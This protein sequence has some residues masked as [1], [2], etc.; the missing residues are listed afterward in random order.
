MHQIKA[1]STRMTIAAMAVASVFSSTLL[2]A[3]EPV[4]T[5]EK[6]TKSETT[7][8]EKIM[9]TAQRRVENL[10][11]TPVAITAVSAETM[12]LARVDSISNISLLT[13]SIK[14]DVTNSAANS[15]N[16]IIRGIGTVGNSRAFEGAVGVFIDGVYRTRAGQAMQNWLDVDSLQILRGPQGTLFG[17]NTSAGAVLIESTK[18]QLNENSVNYEVSAGDYGYLMARAALNVETGDNTAIRIAGLTSKQDGFIENPNGGDYN[19]KSPTAVKFQIYSEP[20]DTFNWQFIAD[21]SKE[22]VNCCYGQVDDIDGPLQPLINSFILAR[23]LELPSSDFEDYQQ[24]LSNDTDQSVKDAGAVLKMNWDLGDNLSL[25]SVTGYRNWKISQ[26]NMDADF[27]GANILGITES[28]ETSLI[29]QEF[30]L[31]GEIATDSLHSANYIFGVYYADEEIDAHHEL[32]WGNQ[33]QAYFDIL[34]GL[35]PGTADATEGKWS[36]LDMPATSETK[37]VFTH[38]KL[39][40]TEKLG[41]SV[42]L[43]YSKDDKT[44]AM[45]RNYFTPAPNAAFRLIGAQ[46]GPEFDESFSDSALS[47]SIALQYQI[48]SNQMMYASYSRGYKAGGINIDNTAAGTNLNNPDEVPGATPLSP[49]YRSEFIDGF[50]LGLKSD[51]LDGSARTNLAVFYNDIKD[52]QI[53]QFIGTRFTVDNAP[54]ATVYGLE[55]ENQFQI[56]DYV[57]LDAD[58]TWLPEAKFGEGTALNQA[59]TV[60][61]A[62]RDFAQAPEW[63]GNLTL[64]TYYPI[65]SDMDFV[66]R[67]TSSYAGST[68]TNTSNDHRRDGQTEWHFNIGLQN[69][70]QSWGVFLWCQNCTDERYPTQHFNSPLQGGD[71]NTYVSAPRMYGVTV[72]GQ[73]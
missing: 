22:D 23:G 14:F 28:L 60:N 61:L 7:Q 56:N 70:D 46:P 53:A 72:R 41:L 19:E 63:A 52:L 35:P 40:L 1:F 24:V 51:Y 12:A 13:P 54:E 71:A 5:G 64:S 59:S 44:G 30:T 62:N 50:E 17:K 2:H 49:K 15:A 3:Q 6:S 21:Y 11:E 37:A 32:W 69:P 57:K 16:I 43:R 33:A 55:L 26:I 47:G 45:N 39:G 73:F 68:F 34:L 58:I 42:G 20:S 29:S 27:T 67:F 18:P 38:W 10:Q 36:D 9:V 25:S 4:E 65:S 31:N 48:S 8:I 66:G